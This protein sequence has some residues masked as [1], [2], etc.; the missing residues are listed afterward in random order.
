M[1]EKKKVKQAATK[2]AKKQAAKTAA[3]VTVQGGKTAGAAAMALK[4]PAVAKPSDEEGEEGEDEV[5]FDQITTPPPK[6]KEKQG[7]DNSKLSTPDAERLP[8]IPASVFDAFMA[9]GISAS[10]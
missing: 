5:D 6:K 1:A 2:A 10:D 8:P 7:K 3:K 9:V 4:K